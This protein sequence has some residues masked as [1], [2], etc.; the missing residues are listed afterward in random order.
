MTSPEQR[1]PS[2]AHKPLDGGARRP[3]LGRL[4]GLGWFTQMGEPAATQAVWML[5]DDPLLRQAMVEY[6]GRRTQVDLTG[7][8]WFVPEVVHLDRARPDLEGMQVVE[9]EAV[10]RVVVEMKF[11]AGLGTEQIVAYLRNQ[12][13][14]LGSSPGA[15]VL[16]VPRQRRA[17][18]ERVLAASLDLWKGGLVDRD[19]G[20]A[21]VTWD[22]WLDVWDDA[23]ST[24]PWGPQSIAADVAQLRA[25]CA[26]LSGNFI[27][28]FSGPDL[29]GWRE[30]EGDLQQLV[31]E[32]TRG[33]TD[34]SS[35][36]LP[37]RDMGAFWGRYVCVWPGRDSYYAVAVVPRLAA[38]GGTPLWVLFHQQT[39][40]FHLIRAR[41]LS[42]VAG[43]N[44]R[45]DDGSL[46]LPLTVPEGLAGVELIESV[47]AQVREIVAVAT[48][49]DDDVG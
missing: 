21:V 10:P 42:S 9:G 43:R 6:L 7:V 45:Q 15:I 40:L 41:I 35:R 49:P 4:A 13:A 47:T 36:L 20:H 1:A 23:A 30:R 33:L 19:V 24:V 22:E 2:A 12:D 34:P 8:E 3:L 18:A 46:W 26:T 28:P 37:A 29:V 32:V 16:L 17:E 39:D 5:L 48:Q 38:V 14:R 27:A 44:A 25:M 11:G 31:R